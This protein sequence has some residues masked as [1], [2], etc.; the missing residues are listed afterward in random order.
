MD[1]ADFSGT[2]RYRVIRRL[3]V[4]GMGVVYEA[5][6]REKGRR[7]ALKTLRRA[8]ADLLY[9]LKQE[10]RALADLEHPNLVALY[11]LVADAEGCY[12]TM[13]LVEGV[14]L[15]HYAAAGKIPT[16][17]AGVIT[18]FPGGDADDMPPPDDDDSAA[19]TA[20][21]GPMPSDERRLRRALAQL[22]GAVDAL[23]QAGKLHRDIKP[24]NAIVTASG[25][26]VLLDLGLVL[27][28]LAQDGV[29]SSGSGR[30]VG[31]AAY[32][33]P[34][35]AMADV[36]LGP[37]A[38]WYSVG[39]VLYQALTGRLPF[40]GPHTQVLMDKQRT[41][42][43]PPRSVAANVPPELDALCVDLLRLDPA[44]R[45]DADEILRRL[46]EA[47]PTPLPPAAP[48]APAALIG[49]DRELATLLDAVAAGSARAVVV[50][51]PS[52]IGKTALLRAFLSRVR[53]RHAGA[54][55][56][57][58]RCYERETV[59]YR[60][61][62]P[63]ID[64]LSHYWE[65]LPPEQAALL[66]PRDAAALGQLFPVL[67]RVRMVDQAPQ[68]R[69]GDP[70]L[71]R[72]RAYASLRDLFSRLAERVPLLLVLD[73]L[74]WVD[75]DTLVL[76][77]DLM[78]PPD[79]PPLLLLLSTRPE[80]EAGLARLLEQVDVVRDR[81]D[82]GVLAG[83]AAEA[84][85]RALLGDGE[86]GGRAA[87]VA[88]EAD[89]N[90][91]LIGQLAHYLEVAGPT[92]EV[93]LD[94][95]LSWRLANLP[96]PARA[97]LE[98]IAIAGEPTRRRSV[99]RASAMDEVAFDEQLR[100]LRAR[101]LLLA[102]ARGP[103]DLLETYHDS[104]R[105]AVVGAVAPERRAAVHRDLAGALTGDAPE[106][107]MAKH[108]ELA[109][110]P[111]R[112][113]EHAA[114]AGAEALARLEFD[115]AAGLYR[116]ALR[117]GD[118]GAA[119]RRTLQIA[120]GDAL[121][122]AGRASQA[123][124]AYLAAAATAEPGMALELNRRAAEQ[125]LRGGHVDRGLAT[126]DAVMTAVGVRMP[127]RGAA[128]LFALLM[129]R[130][131]L[132]LRGRRW[133][134]RE[135]AQVPAAALIRLD[136]YGAVGKSLP[137]VDPLRG[138]YAL[139]R[140]L[141]EALRLGEPVR[142]ARMLAFE[143]GYVSAFG[144][145]ALATRLVAIAEKE[146]QRTGDVEA[147]ALAAVAAGVTHYMAGNRWRE[148]I[149]ALVEAGQRS[150]AMQ[151]AGWET[152]GVELFTNFALMYRG[153]VAELTRR[154]AGQV[155][156]ARRRGDRYHEVSVRTR[157]GLVWLAADDA[158]RAERDVA[159]AIRSWTPADHG[160]QVQHFYALHG[161]CEARLYRADIAAAGAELDAQ[162]KA[163]AGSMLLR[164]PI[165]RIEAAYLAGRIAIAR[166]D[167]RAAR[168]EAKII[169][170]TKLPLGRPMSLLIGAGADA[171]AGKTDRAITS[172]RDAI[173]ALEKLDTL[174]HAH[175]AR[176]RLGALVGG[177]EGEALIAEA[178]AWMAGQGIRSPER[179]AGMILPAPR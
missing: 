42:P 116:M 148:S 56:L 46:G 95:A 154:V 15:L 50:A 137:I 108:R 78:R 109:G 174:L 13:E 146:A 164:V 6:D 4:G 136:A 71:Q 158:D 58:G 98:V 37:A 107:R 48:A 178:D 85:A 105:V 130:L 35:Q 36:Q 127:R 129:R 14:D 163:L 47:A 29:S 155:A 133:K 168:R 79:P 126:A 49:R 64:H 17:A 153:E 170:K 150:K 21:P 86:R 44:S 24:A 75:A 32:M 149:D 114:R 57:E 159:D 161:L 113:A 1:A 142:V 138:A 157:L 7:V 45:P 173:T 111:A 144:A 53:E 8:D 124:D 61:M 43:P 115:R 132:R 143:V 120:E 171:L 2:A 22:V 80:G 125:L 162:R 97:L 87:A 90:P 3:G 83:D 5:E 122:H 51:G 39:V 88:R 101:H 167:E 63:L 118:L 69:D 72:T 134:P 65:R 55:A 93:K 52:G 117:L 81:I 177:S 84:L 82:L 10:F 179:L 156:E 169:G 172:L 12:F 139:T 131:Q 100:L 41:E 62:D 34:E 54:V 68:R 123:A 33:A 91:F 11:D 141:I 99:L 151:A 16:S 106:E 94:Q 128:T 103:D 20:A 119:E 96:A 110:E 40:R 140:A 147:L 60:A 135:A 67:R 25:R 27:D 77:A 165:L 76:L 92:A 145:D 59:P 121:A 102:G 160:Y 23:H 70:Q 31:T 26:L 66:T 28:T 89:G 152:D 104:I 73:D 38:D 112:A 19:D 74:Q 176:R 175:A 166:G 18:P 9:R 30:V